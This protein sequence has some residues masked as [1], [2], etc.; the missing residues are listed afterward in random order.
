MCAK[1][2]R[3]VAVLVLSFTLFLGICFVEAQVGVNFG[4]TC[5]LPQYFDTTTFQCKSC[6]VNYQRSYDSF[7]CACSE[8]YIQTI[9]STGSIVCNSCSLASSRDRS[10]CM[11]CSASTLGFDSSIKDCKCGG[12]QKLVE[13]D[14]LGNYLTNKECLSCGLNSIPDPN[15]RYTCKSCPDLLMISSADGT[16][17]LCPTGYQKWEKSCIYKDAYQN[18]NS[19][20]PA[21]TAS[22]LTYTQVFENSRSGSA[23]TETIKSYFFYQN[24]YRA[25]ANCQQ[26][27]EAKS[28]Q[29]LSN[30]CVLQL[31]DESTP[32]CKMYFSILD[33]IKQDRTNGFQ[34][35]KDG[36]PFLKYQG[37][38]DEILYNSNIKESIGLKGRNDRV[39]R[40]VFI[41]AKYSMD[42][43]WIG[44]EYL[45]NQLQLCPSDA[46]KGS[47]F[48]DFGNQ[49]ENYCYFNVFSLINAAEPLF[50]ELFLVDEGNTL[51]PVPVQILKD[52]TKSINDIASSTLYRRFF[53]YDNKAGITSD[54]SSPTIIRFLEYAELRVSINPNAAEHIYPPT[55]TLKYTA[56]KVSITPTV[57]SNFTVYDSETIY[58]PSITFKVSYM[59]SQS[60]GWILV[61]VFS[62]VVVVFSM[63]FSFVE[64]YRYARRRFGQIDFPTIGRMTF[65]FFSFASN[66]LFYIVFLMSSFY[67]LLFK[68]QSNVFTLMPNFDGQDRWFYF[69]LLLLGLIG[70]VFD[71]G[72]EF[73]K[74]CTYDIFFIDWE[75]SKGKVVGTGGRAEGNYTS[76]SIWRSYFMAKEWEKLQRVTWTSLEFSLLVVLLLM[77]GV[78]IVSL[79]AI[80]AEENRL[81]TIFPTHPILR[82]AL[83]SWFYLAISLLQYIFFRFI[84]YRFIRNPIT[85]LIDT[86]SISNISII[87]LT[88]LHYG[89]YIHGESIFR[90]ADASMKEFY[91]SL[92]MESNDFVPRRGLIHS[93]DQYNTDPTLTFEIFISRQVRDNFDKFLLIPIQEEDAKNGFF[94]RFV[95]NQQRINQPLLTTPNLNNLTQTNTIP[96]QLMPNQ[97]IPPQ[98][99]QQIEQTPLPLNYNNQIDQPIQQT[100]KERGATNNP[101]LNSPMTYEFRLSDLFNLNVKK[102]KTRAIP[103]AFIDGYNTINEYFKRIITDIKIKQGQVIEKQLSY[104]LGFVP[105]F[106]YLHD[107]EYFFKDNYESILQNYSFFAVMLRGVE[108]KII[109]FNILLYAILDMFMNSTFGSLMIV[110]AINKVM[111]WLRNSFVKQNLVTKTLLDERFLF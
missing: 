64:A 68:L 67:Y 85:T 52:D 34:G 97:S 16:E 33:T 73:Y 72:Y 53:L 44:Q 96:N 7:T 20:Y 51:Y 98:Q 92:N 90:F 104:R 82:L 65:S 38:A 105:D 60:V 86:C 109:M 40:L 101:M 32:A 57:L 102:A 93:S 61:L 41:L 48:L 4:W 8:G 23:S 49:Y 1:F 6:S 106:I 47:S 91:E 76:V 87:I 54:S 9:S 103:A 35:W 45:S 19:K 84:A 77:D 13:K 74:Q 69:T 2:I 11:G 18:V 70:K 17:C 14:S 27:S 81:N 10:K 88:E 36:L 46:F 12:N 59:Q 37:T 111:L 99:Q 79:S 31:Y 25:A 66:G 43:R 29:L 24:F 110:Y 94:N 3:S 83:T 95:N 55:L 62:I 71:I 80:T 30:L 42:G 108:W 26:F 39:T 15:D 78:N 22:S 100:I 5:S 21:D 75:K 28:C 58:T 89:Y 50:Y 63:F 56:R 107:K